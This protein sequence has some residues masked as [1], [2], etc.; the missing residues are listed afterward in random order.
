MNLLLR[1][2]PPPRT[3]LI[4]GVIVDPHSRDKRF[5]DKESR[6]R[7]HEQMM[8]VSFIY[9]A[10]NML[11]GP[12]QPPFN[13]RF[14]VGRHHLAWDEAVRDHDRVLSRAARG[15]GK[16][17]ALGVAFPIWKAD[18]NH[19]GS[20]G[21][22]FSASQTLAEERLAETK[23]QLEGNEKLLHLLPIGKD[24]IWTKRE[25]RTTTGTLIRGR[26]W[27]TRIRGGHPNW[28]VADDCLDD[29]C[30]YSETVR[31]RVTEFFF[32]AIS[33]MVTPDGQIICVG[34]PLHAADLYSKI[35]QTK[36]YHVINFPAIEDGKPLFPEI[37]S[38]EKLEDKKQE[39]GPTRFAREFQC[40]RP[41][42]MIETLC[43]AVEIER[44]KTGDIVLAHT[45]AWKK[46]IQ[47][48]RRYYIGRLLR[49][50]G[51]LHVTPD[52]PIF[53]QDGFVSSLNLTNGDSVTFPIPSDFDEQL[54][55]IRLDHACSV[56]YLLTSCRSRMYARGSAKHIPSGS[57]GK[58]GAKS[59]PIEIPISEELM[60][61]VGLWLAEGH[62]G[63]KGK[64]LVWSFGLHEKDTFAREVIE[65]VLDI[66]G[67]KCRTVEDVDG[68]TIQIIACSSIVA[69]WFERMFGKGAAN[70]R[71]PQV[72]RNISREM[73]FAICMG[74]IDGDGSV[75]AGRQVRVSSVSN[76]LLHDIQ[77]LLAKCGIVS[78][79]NI[80]K[81][82][83]EGFGFFDN[84]GRGREY[85]FRTSWRLTVDGGGADSIRERRL[86]NRSHSWTRIKE[87]LIPY[88]YEGEV[89][90]IEVE[91]ENSYV[92]D[93]IAVHNC[94]PMT[95]ESSLFP[96]SLFAGSDIRMPY[97]L[98]LPA[99]YWDEMGTVRYAGVDIAMSTE[100]G[101][102]Y[103]VVFIVALD[104]L[105][106]RWIV[107]IIRERGM[108]FQ[109]QK[110]VIKD[111]YVKFRP[112]MFHIEANQMQRVWP[113]ELRRETDIPIRSFFTTGITP[114]KPWR[115]GMTSIAVNKHHIDRGIPS[116]RMSFEN[117]KWRIPRGDER[118]IELTDLWMGELQCMSV[119]S[120]KVVSVGEHDDLTMATWFCD[121]AIRMGGGFSAH[122]VGGLPSDETQPKQAVLDGSAAPLA[123]SPPKI[124]VEENE[125]FDPF[126]LKSYGV[127][128]GNPV[129]SYPGIL[130][131]D[132]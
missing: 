107:E 119:H 100:I 104:K 91:D 30:L 125:T 87:T 69:D 21:Y 129:L 44:I 78:T 49:I 23:E 26:G 20:L 68:N 39:I 118:S 40:C 111:C 72:F 8:K 16:S 25:I 59:V 61:I 60:R 48:F 112:D 96:S 7:L 32:S 101:S 84:D 94:V 42:T 80:Q 54:T 97:R 128:N 120:G 13:G 71:I 93:G 18:I 86:H 38:L 2:D 130:K 124:D 95:D 33:N 88:D 55:S 52:H 35:E 5:D 50:K 127:S 98:G 76:L 62:I 81:L 115:K 79:I 126:G 19:P 27:G 29:E 17:M 34:T 63:A 31:D 65:S 43:G 51:L 74:Y 64:S 77:Y 122:W 103:F 58:S 132:T 121:V 10:V 6:E 22:I 70:K 53:T 57:V 1:Y 28:I 41:K 109:S 47:T 82:G 110:D 90:N 14:M 45:G 12:P 102:D 131:E 92:A 3:P 117:R 15:H 113:Q 67:I 89:F 24:K 106:N 108:T 4:N 116:L 75:E 11:Q 83:G 46:V 123:L 37:Y 36:R 105:G 73:S 9:Y 56:P 114:K 66:F 85:K 99:S